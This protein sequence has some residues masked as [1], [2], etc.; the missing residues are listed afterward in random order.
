MSGNKVGLLRP[1]L[2]RLVIGDRLRSTAD[3]LE[4]I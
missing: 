3:S 1:S 4:Q 2:A